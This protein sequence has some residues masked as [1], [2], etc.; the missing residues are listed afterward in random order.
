VITIKS[1]REIAL[2]REAGRIVALC[3]E[4]IKQNIKPGITTNDIDK[5]VLKVIL[6]ND[7]T[8]TFKGYGDF[9]ANICTSVNE[10][11]VHGIPN[12]NVL[13]EG[14]IISIDIGVTYKG[15]IGDSAW[16]YPVGKISTESQMLLEQTQQSLWVG[17]DKVKE[18]IHLSDVSHAIQMHANK[19][20]L[21]IVEELCGHGVGSSLHEDPHILNFGKPG[22]GPILKAGMTLAIEPMLNLGTKKIIFHDDGW[23]TSTADKKYSAHFE[24]TIL[25]TEDGY[26][27]LTKL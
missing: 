10:H 14:D 5:I 26:E 13:N 15:Y 16:T 8:P 1:K 7:A 24:H 3:H 2:M 12:D 9:P 17:L 6:D 21:G 4:E 19:Y 23:T 27:V 22:K 25:V 11:V 20:N 18:G